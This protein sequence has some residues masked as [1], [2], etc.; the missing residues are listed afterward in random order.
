MVL[1]CTLNAVLI[2]SGCVS[3]SD[4]SHV[5][6]HK[7]LYTGHRSNGTDHKIMFIRHRPH[8]SHKSMSINKLQ[9]KINWSHIIC[10]MSLYI[11]NRLLIQVHMTQVILHISQIN[12]HRSQ[13]QINYTHSI[14]S[15]LVCDRSI[16]KFW[17]IVLKTSNTWQIIQQ[18]SINRISMVRIEVI[19]FDEF[20]LCLIV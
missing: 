3:S 14:E 17:Y 18:V 9:I 20:S 10:Y 16:Q 15:T 4:R 12:V 2:S 5:L 7:S 13:I 8:I 1:E 11:D 19:R 6:G